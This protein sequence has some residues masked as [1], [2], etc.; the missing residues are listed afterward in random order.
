MEHLR[1][2]SKHIGNIIILFSSQKWYQMMPYVVIILIF[3]IAEV[4]LRHLIYES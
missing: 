3:G 4:Y 1:K 2:E